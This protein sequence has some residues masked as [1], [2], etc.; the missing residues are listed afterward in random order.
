MQLE[1]HVTFTA[2]HFHGF[3]WPP[4]PARLFQGLVAATHRGAHGLL[5]ADVRDRALEWLESCPA[6]AIIAIATNP[7]RE[8]ITNYV[9]NNDDGE[10]SDFRE[11]VKAAK[12]LRLHPLP[13]DC[14]VTYR[15]E[16]VSDGDATRHADVVSAMASLVTHLGRT[17]DLVYARGEV[18]AEST[19]VPGDGRKVWSARETPG[20]MWL[21]PKPGFLK[22][23]QERH[24]RSVSELPPDFTNSR[25]VDYSGSQTSLDEIPFAVFEL[26]RLDGRRLEF[27][28][29]RIREPA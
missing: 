15:W 20:G 23:C 4:S 18:R 28:P 27:E 1:I 2:G 10:S 9:P 5:H 25:Q 21:A 19:V 24:P 6:P 22:L 8:L 7:A 17:V 26:F 12:S 16:F 3:E 11:H 13:S 29:R 14:R